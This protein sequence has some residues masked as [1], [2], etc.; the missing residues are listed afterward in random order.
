MIKN[1]YYNV[2]R[3]IDL[4]WFLGIIADQKY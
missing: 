2:K 1:L 3:L 4:C